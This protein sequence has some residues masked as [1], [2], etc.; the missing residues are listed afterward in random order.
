[1]PVPIS[2]LDYAPVRPN[3]TFAEAISGSVAVAQA[4]EAAGYRRVWYAEHHNQSMVA[5]AATSILIAHVASR[6]TTIRIGSGGIMLPNHSPMTVAEQFGTLAALYPQRIDL[7]VGRAPGGNAN[8]M[9]ALRR[10]AD[11]GERFPLDVL[12]LQAFL[13]ERSAVDGVEA[14]PGRASEVPI[15]I[16]GSSLFGARLAAE[17]GLPFVYASHFSPKALGQAISLYRSNFRSSDQ[18]DAPYVIVSVNVIAADDPATAALHHRDM[19]RTE[20]RKLLTTAPGREQYSDGEIDS[21]LDSPEGVTASRLFHHTAVGTPNTVG[22][23]L[24]RLVADT[25]ANELILV[26][27]APEATQRIRSLELTAAVLAA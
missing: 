12:E 24:D 23:H 4:A 26:H 7:G 3:Q 2:I 9:Y 27:Q 6:T 17:M 10:G 13:S 19:L 22:Q 21:F 15:Y 5:S 1:M 8:T 16:L 18:I 14:Y 20:A 11:A 25:G